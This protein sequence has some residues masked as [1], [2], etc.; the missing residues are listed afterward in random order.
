MG[1]APPS[2]PAVHQS[3]TCDGDGA[4]SVLL[5]HGVAHQAAVG[6]IST[7]HHSQ[8]S[9]HVKQTLLIGHLRCGHIARQRHTLP[10]LPEHLGLRVALVAGARDGH[11]IPR[12]QVLVGLQG[13]AGLRVGGLREAKSRGQDKARTEGAQWRNRVPGAVSNRGQHWAV[14]KELGK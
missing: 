12:L 8:N 13:H 5:Q 4:V 14:G 7:Q 3:P 10:I 11:Y 6:A 1:V 2:S 9:A